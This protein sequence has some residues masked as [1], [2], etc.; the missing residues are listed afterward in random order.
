MSQ[1][2]R[3]RISTAKKSSNYEGEYDGGH[4]KSSNSDKKNNDE[5]YGGNLYN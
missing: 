4:N 1:T 3:R 5:G 2:Q